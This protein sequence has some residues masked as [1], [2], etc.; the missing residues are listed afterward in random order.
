MQMGGCGCCSR[1]VVNNLVLVYFTNLSARA[2]CNVTPCMNLLPLRGRKAEASLWLYSYF[3][4]THSSIPLFLLPSCDGCSNPRSGLVLTLT[5]HVL[6]SS[7]TSEHVQENSSGNKLQKQRHSTRVF[8]RFPP[9]FGGLYV[10]AKGT[11]ER[12]VFHDA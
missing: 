11:V 5:S 10:T 7:G 12:K 3:Q 9:Q 2:I 4:P 8:P 6:G 1:S